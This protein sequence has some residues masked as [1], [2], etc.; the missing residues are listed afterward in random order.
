MFFYGGE[1]QVKFLRQF[2]P[3]YKRRFYVNI[4]FSKHVKV[5]PGWCA[6]AWSSQLSRLKVAFRSHFLLAFHEKV[7]PYPATL[8]FY[9]H[10]LRALLMETSGKIFE[11]ESGVSELYGA[12]WT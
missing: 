5:Q 7:I 4:V 10:F 1:P 8:Y 11:G 3:C 12:S 2:F 6:F 9:F